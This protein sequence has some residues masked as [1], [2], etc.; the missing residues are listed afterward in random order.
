MVLFASVIV[1]VV[2]VLRCLSSR[3]VRPRKFTRDGRKLCFN[4][5]LNTGFSPENFD[6]RITAQGQSSQ[7]IFYNST[8]WKAFDGASW[9]QRWRRWWLAPFWHSLIGYA[10]SKNRETASPTTFQAPLFLPY[11]IPA[12]SLAPSSFLNF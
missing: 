2:F 10:V 12:L 7:G 4:D 9:S 1:L 6:V 8:I 5:F 3:L 11:L